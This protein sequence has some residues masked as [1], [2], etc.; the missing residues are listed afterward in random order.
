ME[1]MLTSEPEDFKRFLN[2]SP[3]ASVPEDERIDRGAFRYQKVYIHF[4]VGSDHRLGNY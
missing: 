3:D 1:K 4:A 2:S